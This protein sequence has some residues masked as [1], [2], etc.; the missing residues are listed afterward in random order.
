[1]DEL[2]MQIKSYANVKGTLISLITL[3]NHCIDEMKKLE[4]DFAFYRAKQVQS[5]IDSG[6]DPNYAQR[7]YV[8]LRYVE[9]CDGLDFP[10]LTWEYLAA[11]HWAPM[12]F[13]FHGCGT[14]VDLNFFCWELSF[15]EQKWIVAAIRAETRAQELRIIMRS[16]S[17]LESQI[18]DISRDFESYKSG[19]ESHFA[20]GVHLLDKNSIDNL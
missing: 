3:K 18:T 19:A 1:M 15:S 8:V 13:G 6:E 7:K 17:I 5:A 14:V 20:D 16:I 4:A 12:T 10:T 11:V 9:E 2:S